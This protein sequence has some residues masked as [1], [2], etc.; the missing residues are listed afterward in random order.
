MLIA[1][2]LTC[3]KPSRKT[4]GECAIASDLKVT[5]LCRLRSPGTISSSRCQTTRAT[6]CVPFE[7]HDRR[8]RISCFS[9]EHKG[10]HRWWSQTGSNRRPPACKAGALPTEL[11]PR[12][13]GTQRK[14]NLVGLGRFELPTS[15]LSSARSNQLSYRP[16]SNLKVHTPRLRCQAAVGTGCQRPLDSVG[17]SGKKEKR[18][19]RNPAKDLFHLTSNGP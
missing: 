3:V 2:A 1:A 15:R 5:D 9:D 18:R 7:G 12:S 19:R 8:A 16:N 17:S 14:R 6:P 13:C 4:S 10:D 11:W